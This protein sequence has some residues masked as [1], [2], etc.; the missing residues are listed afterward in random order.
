MIRSNL[1]DYS[2]A[3]ALVKGTITVSNKAAGGA[4]I[5]NTNIKVN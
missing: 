4:A 3:Y 5:N 2:Y 1:Y